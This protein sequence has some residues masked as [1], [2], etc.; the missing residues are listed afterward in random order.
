M[1]AMLAASHF[2]SSAG[3]ERAGFHAYSQPT[4]IH[5]ESFIQL[6]SFDILCGPRPILQYR[7]LNFQGECATFEMF[8]NAGG[9][10]SVSLTASNL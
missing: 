1:E 6:I 5:V 10:K 3:K 8:C 2:L 7:P 4:L 9:L